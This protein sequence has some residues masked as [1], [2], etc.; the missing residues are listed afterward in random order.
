[1]YEPSMFLNDAFD[2]LMRTFER[3]YKKTENL[4]DE[5]VP[6][7]LESTPVLACYDQLVKLDE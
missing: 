3:K 5:K 1:M 7:E 2:K 4:F 6:L